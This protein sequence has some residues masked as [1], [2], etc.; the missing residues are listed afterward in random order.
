MQKTVAFP[1]SVSFNI[2]L[3]YSFA[4]YHLNIHM[5]NPPT[6]RIKFTATCDSTHPI[7]GIIATKVKDIPVLKNLNFGGV[8]LFDGATNYISEIQRIFQQLAQR[9]PNVLQ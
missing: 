9:F 3:V 5:N 1:T 2:L 8:Y 6:N 7:H 4:S